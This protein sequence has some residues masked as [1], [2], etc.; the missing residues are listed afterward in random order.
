LLTV[1]LLRANGC[2]VLGIDLDAGRLALARQFGAEI[3]D[4]AHGEDPV[5]RGLAFSGGRGV[6]AVI[7]TAST[8]SSLPIEQ[9][10]K[11]SRK[12]G[13]IVL[14]GVT[15]LELN[16]ADF[17]EKELTFRFPALTVRAV[18]TSL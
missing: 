1:Q 8:Q 17:Y 18:T 6:D 7:V 3:C 11:M 5:A 10:A 2:R 16:R 9:A 4:L 15:G 12:R 14:V 13:R